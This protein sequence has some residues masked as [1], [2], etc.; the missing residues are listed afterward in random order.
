MKRQNKYHF[1]FGG[2]RNSLYL[3][4]VVWLRLYDFAEYL[5]KRYFTNYNIKVMKKLLL[6]KTMLLLCALIVGGSSVWADDYEL[7]SG[8]LTEGDYIIVYDNGAMKNTVSSSRFDIQAV[9][10]SEGIITNPG[11]AIIWHIAASGDYW[12]IYNANV[13]KYAASTGAKNKAQ[14]L[15]DGTDDK[16]LWEVSVTTNT[17]D[18]VNKQNKANGVNANLRCNGNY[19]F[20]CYASSTGGALSLYKKVESTATPTTVTINATGIT[21]TN[22]FLGTEAGTLTATVTYGSPASP[23]PGAA[24]TWSSS[25]T[26]VATVGENTG[27]VTLVGEGSTTITASYA[28]KT[29][30]YKSSSAEYLLNVIEED[31]NAITLWSEDFSSYSADDVP[32]G[33]TFNYSVDNGG[34]TTK[35]YENDMAGG[36]SPELLVAKNN[37]YFQAIVPLENVQGSLKLKFKKYNN[38]LAVSTSTEG[39]SISGES[40]FT[41]AGEFTV[42]FTG[43]TVNMT[44]IAIKFTSTSGSNVRIDDIELKGSQVVPVT[45]SA[46]GL[47]TFAS[48]SKLDFTNVENLEAYIAKENGGKIELT[49]VNKVPA[50]TGVLLRALNSATDFVVPVT[51]AATDDV[52]G[53][54]FKRGTGADV[55]TGEGPYNYVLGKH[56]GVV[57]FYKAG[58]MVVATNKAYLQTTIAAA[59]IDVNFDET[60][61]LTLVNSEKKTV[62]SD[63]FDLQGRKVAN[64]T[65]GLYIVNGKKVNVK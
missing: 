57:G 2:F 33:G 31:P 17:Y 20:A 28:G 8:A 16:S 56:G 43:V 64:P 5:K 39:I 60:T 9:T 50:E 48:D 23:V 27:V 19:G 58:G 12:T 26:S 13:N 1:F 14:L 3:C 44:S 65:K 4:N 18:F 49:K 51:T 54:L 15:A 62:N 10:I 46:A 6:M 22:K 53:N 30:E 21:N 61:A 11:A 41:S 32:S 24:V 34:G 36:T 7:Y 38:A 42:T 52:T 45:I 59:R 29:G 25:D 40:S 35:I 55:A 47:A 63:V 37:G